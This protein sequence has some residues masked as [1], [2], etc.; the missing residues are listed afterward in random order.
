M[1]LQSILTPI[2]DAFQ[3]SFK[4]LLA[5]IAPAFNWIC[6]VFAIVAIAYWLR[7]QKRYSQQAAENGTIH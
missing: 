4:H 5:P 2:V 6:I 1:N 7:R 3:W